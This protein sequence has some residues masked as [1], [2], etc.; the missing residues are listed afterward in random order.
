MTVTYR[1]REW[2]KHFE[3]SESNKRKGS[4]KWVALPTKHDGKSYR[5]LMRLPNADAIYGAWMLLVAVAGK[6]PIRGVLADDEGPLTAEDLEDK[7]GLPARAFATAIEVLASDRFQW[8]EVVHLP[9]PAEK[10][11]DTSAPCRS[12]PENQPTVQDKTEHDSTGHD[13]V[14]DRTHGGTWLTPPAEEFEVWWE[15]YPRRTGK[16]EAEA[17]WEAA[18]QV[19]ASKQRVDDQ[20]AVAWLL[21]RTSDFRDSPAGQSPVSGNDFRPFPSRWLESGRYDDDLTEW[22]KPN[23]DAPKH[24]KPGKAP[25]RQIAGVNL[26][27]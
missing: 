12:L 1:I 21:K 13:T 23:G 27:D 20:T 17:A 16:I 24:T 4:L 5:R 7:T 15:T 19:I 11:A 10:T 25:M 26:D 14:P 18:I 3:T 22:A 6:C 8:L 2:S 9:E